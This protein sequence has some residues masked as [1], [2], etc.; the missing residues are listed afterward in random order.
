MEVAAILHQPGLH[1]P[2]WCPGKGVPYRE[3]EMLETGDILVC[4]FRQ[5]T[6]RDIILG[7]LGGWV[8]Q[9]GKYPGFWFANYHFLAGSSDG[10]QART[11]KHNSAFGPKS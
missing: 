6:K 1:T 8:L 3:S 5:I 2:V 11:S 7:N 4:D 9:K 10:V